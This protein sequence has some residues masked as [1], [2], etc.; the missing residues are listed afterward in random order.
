[1]RVLAYISGHGYGHST[2]VVALLEALRERHPQAAITLRTQV[3]AWLFEVALKPPYDHQ[4]AQIDA[5]VVELDLL[6]QDVPGTLAACQA[7]YG[8][9]DEVIEREVAAASALRPDLILS[10]IPPLASAVGAR[11]GVRTVALGNFSWDFIYGAYINQE[12]AFAPIV[13]RCA[14]LYRQTSLLLRLPFCHE[15]TAFPAQVDIPLIARWPEQPVAQTRAQLGLAAD[16]P[17]PV[18]LVVSRHPASGDQMIASLVATG[19]YRVLRFGPSSQRE[20]GLWLLGPE[21]QSRFVDVLAACDA[22]VSKLGYGLVSECLTAKT[23]ILYPPRHDFAE[24]PILAAGL[25]GQLPSRCVSEEDFVAGRLAEPLEALLAQPGE[26]AQP[27][28][29]APEQAVAAMLG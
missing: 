24:Y 18:V 22:V 2:R 12:P 17:R 16:D 9:L 21:W 23:A 3:P 20:E 25:D 10:D 7:F 4:T 1:M 19:Q 29:N 5:G 6:R 8:R 11:L 28:R 26:F 15:M 27:P 13:A 14:E